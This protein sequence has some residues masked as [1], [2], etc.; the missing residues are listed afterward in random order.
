M[1]SKTDEKE[2]KIELVAATNKLVLDALLSC[3]NT[4]NL[5]LASDMS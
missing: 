3:A 5:T 1:R 4:G 2:I